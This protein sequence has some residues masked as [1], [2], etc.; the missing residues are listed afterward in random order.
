MILPS[1]NTDNKEDVLLNPNLEV[2]TKWS[3]SADDTEPSITVS[4]T[5]GESLP[6][7]NVTVTVTNAQT[8]KLNYGN[9]TMVHL[10]ISFVSV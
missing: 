3:S 8:V 4:T 10:Y 7:M 1:S 2:P 5:N 6:V 9:E